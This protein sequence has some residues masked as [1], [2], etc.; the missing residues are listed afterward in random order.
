MLSQKLAST[1]AN[2]LKR[3]TLSMNVFYDELVFTEISESSKTDLVDLICQAG[4]ML[5]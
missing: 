5:G 2:K 4:G 1:I 3:K